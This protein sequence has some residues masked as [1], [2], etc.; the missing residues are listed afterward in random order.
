MCLNFYFHCYTFKH[1]LLFLAFTVNEDKGNEGEGKS[2]TFLFKNK[3]YI[4]LYVDDGGVVNV[5][6]D[7]STLNNVFFTETNACI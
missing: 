4:C 5:Q 3:L 2:R 7:K 6:V 1:G